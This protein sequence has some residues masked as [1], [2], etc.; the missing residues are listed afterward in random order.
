[1]ENQLL[2]IEFIDPNSRGT[3]IKMFDGKNIII[4][5]NV[6]DF[7][8]KLIDLPISYK[9]QLLHLDINQLSSFIK[10]SQNYYN[11]KVLLNFKKIW[12]W[13]IDGEIYNFS[14]KEIN[15]ELFGLFLNKNQIVSKLKRNTFKT[16]EVFNLINFFEN[17]EDIREQEDE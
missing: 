8:K 3:V 17:N 4:G 15:N 11:E 13:R 5:K 12:I 7:Y 16:D 6:E 14:D 2:E 1:M 9:C 10:E